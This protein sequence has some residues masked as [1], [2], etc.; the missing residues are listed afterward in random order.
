MKQNL[1]S[2]EP[3]YQSYP[4]LVTI[5]Q[6]SEMLNISKS[7]CYRLLH[8]SELQGI[9]IGRKLLIPKQHVVQYITAKIE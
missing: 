2:R 6:L 1:I 7:S 3:M 9:N 8:S 4:E 5:T